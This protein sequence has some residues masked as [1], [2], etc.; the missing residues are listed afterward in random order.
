MAF[1]D[2]TRDCNAKN[3]QIQIKLR[4]TSFKY[5]TPAIF[6]ILL[7]SS[8]IAQ[9][10]TIT[11]I[12]ADST[13]KEPLAF[14]NIIY[15][16]DN[17]GTTSN[18]DG[19]FTIET[20]ENIKF[21]KFSYIG[22]KPKIIY[23]ENIKPNEHLRVLLS[24]NTLSLSEVTV[25][26]GINPAHRIINKV[27]ENKD[28]NNPEKLSSFTYTSYN[29]LYFTIDLKNKTVF[30]DTVELAEQSTLKTDTIEKNTIKNFFA[31]QY[32]LLMET[33]SKRKFIYPDKNYEEVIAT[34]VSG[35]KAPSL[36][37]LA[38]QLQSFSFYNEMI[39]ISDKHYL[40]PVCNGSTKKYLFIIEDTLFS[41]TG[42]TVFMIS[43]R[44]SRGKNFDG[45]EGVL[46]INSNKYAIENVVAQP[47]RQ[48]KNIHFKIQQKY[49]IIDGR[50]WF[51][52]EL[53]S[54]LTFMNFKLDE[55]DTIVT[56]KNKIVRIK[57]TYPLIGIGKTYIS[58]IKT[59]TVY[60]NKKFGVIEVDIKKDAHKKNT[61]F[62]DYY[63][64]MP[65]NAKEIKTYQVIDS[66]G[67]KAKLDMKIKTI[68]TIARGYI[69][70]FC[71]NIDINNLMKYNEFE[72]LRS[73]LKL[74]TNE[75]ISR[76]ASVGGYFAYGLLD[77][78]I[79]YGGN[80]LLY[81]HKNNDI[82]IDISY[83]VDAYE[84]ASIQFIDNIMF[85]NTEIYR[86]ILI[87]DMYYNEQ[88][89]ST[90]SLRL[91]KYLKT[92]ISYSKKYISVP[93]N[94]IFDNNSYLN[95]FTS[96]E[97]AV[98][99]KYAYKE[100]FMKTPSG[101]K[102]P[103]GTKYPIVRLNVTK[104]FDKEENSFDFLKV[105]TKISKTFVS[106]NYGKTSV[107]VTGGIID[108][109]LPYFMQYNGQGSYKP[110]TVETANSFATMRLNEFISDKFVYLFLRHDFG[111]LIFKTNKFHP[112]I[113]L[114]HN[115]GAGTLSE[116][117]THINIPYKTMEKVYLESGIIFN[118]LIK[119][120]FFEYG[121]GIYY[122]YGQQSLYTLKDNVA[123][124]LSLNFNM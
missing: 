23:T 76:R 119:Q 40:S 49:K 92:K 57:E 6:A 33:V 1:S 9:L 94:Y 84:S 81:L 118:N 87:K 18:I 46:Y 17:R 74:L 100:K 79:K 64:T 24:K 2:R 8:S 37:I 44:P 58:E 69:P 68:E 63:R 47:Y 110:F 62:W 93:N 112:K 102:I 54:E 16:N 83:S 48:S 31:A 27:I 34:K 90:L 106:K 99:F 12:I 82:N 98:K 103:L 124:R 15:N 4:K 30:K 38:T 11:G 107:T 53:N 56:D 114:C 88:M 59:D 75:K 117:D 115:T 105:E 96:N 50:H 14:V 22:Y 78:K 29:K 19:K 67:E 36:M 73:G 43:Y 7:S 20:D 120:D 60:E 35:L 71:F 5:I 10:Y 25:L 111:S 39:N 97:F 122:R 116:P 65:L 45:L 108:K 101:Y 123:V 109:P 13:T 41:E 91:I 61:E 26:P 113:I 86:T 77:K 70:F 42:D 85:N 21:L 51:P 72:G 55:T 104:G 28:I 121:I 3:G 95:S 66:I 52:V 80:L 32:L 89:Q